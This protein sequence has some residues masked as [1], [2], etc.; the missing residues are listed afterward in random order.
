MS[1]VG[2]WHAAL[3]FA[4]R[5][6]AMQ[7]PGTEVVTV[8]AAGVEFLGPILLTAGLLVR[9][10]SIA[11]LILMISMEHLQGAMDVD[12]FC[13]A[14]LGWYATH[15]AGPVSFD[16]LLGRGLQTSALPFAA[17]AAAA[18][19]WMDHSISPA[20]RFALRI[21]LALGLIATSLPS[22]LF[23]VET[24][25]T[26]SR[27]IAL[28]AA[29]FLVLGLATPLAALAVAVALAATMMVTPAEGVS[30]LAPLLF[31][32]LAIRGAGRFSIDSVLV[33]NLSKPKEADADAPHVVIVGGGFGGVACAAGLRGERVR[34]TLI[35]RNNYH[36]FQPLLYQV[37]TAS[38]SPGD[39][40]TPI[41]NV[42]RDDSGLTV[43]RGAVSGIDAERA[44][45]LV[46]GR[47]VGYDYL[48]LAT[49]ASHNYFGNDQWAGHAPALK[50]LRDAVAMRERI[51]EAFERAEATSDPGEREVLLTFLVCG[52]GPTGVELAGAITE[53]ARHGLEHAFRR[54][55]PATARVILVESGPRLLASFP[56]KLSNNARSS[57]ERLGVEVRVGKH[58]ELVDGEGA[59]VNGERIHASTV[60]WTAGVKASPAAEWIGHVPDRAGRVKVA[61]DLSIPGLPNIFAIGDTAL[62]FAWKGT[63]VPGLAPAAKQEG[64]YV[65]SVIA[66][67]LQRAPPP[68]PFRYRHQ[69][70]LATI[71]RKSAVADFGRVRLSGSVAWWLWGAVHVFFLVGW[72]NRV[73]VVIGWAWSYFT[74][75]VGVQLI[76]SDEPRGA[77]EPTVPS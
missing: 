62:A 55:D 8:F 13:A 42:F 15:G 38:L 26:V 57:L 65:A 2:D 77:R 27:L 29:F 45:V 64:A 40:A 68:R 34:V 51:L 61:P 56:E 41:R 5:H 76:T 22:A 39:I 11:M 10:A 20:Y 66:A 3:A 35:D 1:R 75:R 37:A 14:L 67:R 28:P 44:V 33:G 71:G 43:I 16:R 17:W 36:L 25:T 21:W 47:N 60:L 52:G 7:W 46:N 9:P 23:P 69:G 73:W 72:R 6:F 48:V 70:S 59:V 31:A 54:I 12:L 50:T 49:G 58:V 24:L 30:G 63:Q 19:R 74:Y 53:L 4:E 18:G 32:L